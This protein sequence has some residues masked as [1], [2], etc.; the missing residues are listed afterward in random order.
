MEESDLSRHIY[1]IMKTFKDY[2]ESEDLIQTVPRRGYRFAGEVRCGNGELRIEKHTL[3][4]T[5][6]EEIP[7]RDHQQQPTASPQALAASSTGHSISR[8]FQSKVTV[9]G[10]VLLWVIGAGALLWRFN[11][12]K[13][14][15]TVAARDQINRRPAFEIVYAQRRE[16]VS[17]ST[18]H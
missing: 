8:I 10:I 6:I 5:L 3:T 14:R 12:T 15:T 9:L 16:R 11:Q 18:H 2:G 13:A 7:V 17:V 4:Q 1:L